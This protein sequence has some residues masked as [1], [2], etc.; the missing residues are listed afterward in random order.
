MVRFFFL[1]SVNFWSTLESCQSGDEANHFMSG[2]EAIH[3]I[4][5]DE[6]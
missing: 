5:S 1:L 3:F 2:D 6:G 4:F